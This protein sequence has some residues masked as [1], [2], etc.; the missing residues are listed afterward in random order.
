M[1]EVNT[2]FIKETLVGVVTL[3][4]RGL[5]DGGTAAG[6]REERVSCCTEICVCL[7]CHYVICT[8]PN[9]SQTEGRDSQELLAEGKRC[10]AAGDANG[11]V[12]NFQEA[13]ALM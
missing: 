12:E 10:L 11:A 5:P 2:R 4:L 7:A 9:R 3:F 8:P 1:P 6:G 13:C